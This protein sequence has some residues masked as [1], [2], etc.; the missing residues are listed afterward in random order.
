MKVLPPYLIFLGDAPDRLIAK[1]GAGIADWAPERCAGQLRLS[2]G[3]VDLGLPD[4]TIEAARAAGVKTL[5]VGTAS[6]GGA[7]DDRWLAHPAQLT[8]RAACSGRRD[9]V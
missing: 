7:M 9:G 3:T 5:V 4:M 2:A 6:P 8:R 1:T